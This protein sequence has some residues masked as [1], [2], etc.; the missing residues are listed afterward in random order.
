MARLFISQGRLDTWSA[1]D[2]VKVEGDVMTLAGDSRFFRLKPA[3]R[4]VKV[5][6][7]DDVHKL[8]GKVKSVEAVEKLGGEQYMESVLLGDTAY[9]VQSGFI[10][11]PQGV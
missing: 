1:E 9:D 6:G 2:R 7:G 8:L 10:G 4:F 3:V 5:S 11:E